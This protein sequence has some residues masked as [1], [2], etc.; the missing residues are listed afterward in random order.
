MTH[1]KI[2]KGRL[3]LSQLEPNLWTWLLLASNGHVLL[4]APKRYSS[5]RN[6]LSGVETLIKLLGGHHFEVVED[7][8]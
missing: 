4:Q 6:A 3:L 8:E 2:R 7:A 1:A 5:K